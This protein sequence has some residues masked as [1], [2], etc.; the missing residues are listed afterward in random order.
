MQGGQ[1]ARDALITA[2]LDRAEIVRVPLREEGLAGPQCRVMDAQIF[3]EN[4]PPAVDR[5]ESGQRLRAATIVA[6]QVGRGL[7]AFED[8]GVAEG[9]VSLRSIGGDI[10]AV[11]TL[12]ERNF[13]RGDRVAILLRPEKGE[14][15]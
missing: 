11:T 14:A 13:E 9:A 1:L 12:R 5:F 7:F 8:H 3:L 15:F 2:M 4:L 10:S 6:A